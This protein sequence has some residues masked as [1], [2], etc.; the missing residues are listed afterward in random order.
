[1]YLHLVLEEMLS[2]LTD[3]TEEPRYTSIAF[4]SS[5]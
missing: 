2:N 1:M 4:T 5:W 3:S